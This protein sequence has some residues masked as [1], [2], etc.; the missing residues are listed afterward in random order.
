MFSSLTYEY[1]SPRNELTV[2]GASALVPDEYLAVWEWYRQM[3]GKHIAQLPMGDYAPHGLP[4]KVCSQRG[5]HKP[6]LKDLAHGWKNGRDYA[7]TIHSSARGRYRDEVVYRPDGTWSFEYDEQVTESGREHKWDH[8]SPLINCLEDGVPV[9]VIV[10]QNN[11]YT[12]MGLAFVERYDAV[13]GT[14]ALHGPANAATEGKG[15]FDA[16]ASDEL[17]EKDKKRLAKLKSL[18]LDGGDERVRRFVEEVRRERQKQFSRAVFEAYGGH[19]AISDVGVRTALQAAHVDDYR[20]RKS[21]IVQNGILLRADLHLL[22]DANLLGIK[23]D[24]HEIVLADSARVQP[25]R[26]MVESMPKLR[27]PSNHALWPDDELLDLH[28]QRFRMRNHAA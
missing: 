25:Y 5:I 20:S 23:P 18:A 4:I 28:Y 14:F 13:A 12:V 19:C 21:Q 17:S 22:Y 15:H 6:T 24:T 10:G 9:G 8:N 26:A 1:L 11:G 16:F 3:E 27:L 7:L 2:S